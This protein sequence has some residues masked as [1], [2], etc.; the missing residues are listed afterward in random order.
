MKQFNYFDFANVLSEEEMMEIQDKLL[1]M[2]GK[3]MESYYKKLLE[4]GTC[5]SKNKKIECLD[6]LTYYIE[7]RT[8]WNYF[9]MNHMD[10]SVK[11]IYFEFD[12]LFR[13]S[14]EFSSCSQYSSLV[15]KNDD[16]ALDS[17]CNQAEAPSFELLA[18]VYNG[19]CDKCL[20][21]L[22]N[23]KVLIALTISIFK[24]VVEMNNPGIP[25]C[26]HYKYQDPLFRL[27]DDKQY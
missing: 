21:G 17:I 5:K 9:L 16:W 7:L 24:Q 18:I 10:E 4:K 12:T 13:W 8:Q 2:S 27:F 3:E 1:S 15:H 22:N 11:A 23:K 14:G 19:C 25:V 26:I 20:G 6:F